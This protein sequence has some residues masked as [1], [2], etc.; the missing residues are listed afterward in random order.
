MAGLLREAARLASSWSAMRDT[1]KPGENTL[2]VRG[3]EGKRLA[4]FFNSAI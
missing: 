3:E 4:H 2:A 1:S